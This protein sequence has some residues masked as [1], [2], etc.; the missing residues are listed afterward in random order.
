MEKKSNSTKEF[1][2]NNKVFTV[3]YLIWMLLHLIFLLTSPSYGPSQQE[4]WPF[5]DNRMKYYDYTEFLLYSIAPVILYL[6][7]YFLKDDIKRKI[8]ND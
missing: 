2:E 3:I 5:G 1:I 7:Y 6:I 4:F 8:K